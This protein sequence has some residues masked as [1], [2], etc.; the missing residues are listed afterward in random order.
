M[1][2][3]I[4]F[5]SIAVRAVHVMPS[6]L[7]QTPRKLSKSKEHLEAPRRLSLWT[8]GRIYELL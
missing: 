5:E 6:F 8:E 7:L 1:G 2:I 3:N 4:S